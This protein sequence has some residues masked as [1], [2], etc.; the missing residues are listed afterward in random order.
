[1]FDFLAKGEEDGVIRRLRGIDGVAFSFT[2]M[3]Q[4][5]GKGVGL[6]TM[7]AMC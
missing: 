4:V 7:T 1:M 2:C 5:L 3:V 6:A